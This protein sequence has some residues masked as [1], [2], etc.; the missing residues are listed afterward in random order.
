VDYHRC[1]QGANCP[2]AQLTRT[3]LKELS[4]GLSGYER[5]SI[6]QPAG[7]ASIILITDHKGG[8]F[9]SNSGGS[10]MLGDHTPAAKDTTLP[11]ASVNGSSIWPPVTDRHFSPFVSRVLVGLKLD[12]VNDRS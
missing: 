10:A 8:S 1:R 2:T 9:M 7:P 6:K 5:A 4:A 3:C 11:A 12:T